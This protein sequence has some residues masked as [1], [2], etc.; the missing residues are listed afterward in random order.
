[1]VAALLLVLLAAPFPALSAQEKATAQESLQK[2]PGQSHGQSP[3]Q[4]PGQPHGQKDTSAEPIN[5][6]SERV[7][8]DHKA[9]FVTF[10][11]N[12]VATQADATLT[13]DRLKV[14]YKDV[15]SGGADKGGQKG[16]QANGGKRQIERIEAD[17][18]VKIVQVDKVATGEHAVYTAADRVM[19]LTGQPKLWQERNWVRG[20]KVLFYLDE[21]KS[22]VEGAPGKRV[23]SLIYPEGQG[24]GTKPSSPK[25]GK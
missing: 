24:P 10:T 20:T 16:G 13:S 9:N 5:I 1:M 18:H 21:D 4:S 25:A 12:V 7:D 23:E 11:G 8:A 17:G 14:F 15:S 6:T 22:V 19:V 3:G 2:P